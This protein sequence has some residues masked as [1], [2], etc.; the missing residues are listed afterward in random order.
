MPK[1]RPPPALP[2]NQLLARLPQGEY[3]RL[4]PHL[5]AVPLAFKQVLYRA[6]S[7]IDYAYFPNRG[8]TS[9]L[10]IMEDGSAI[11]VATVGNEGVVGM[12]AFLGAKTSPNEV[13]VQ[14]EGD[15]LRMPAEAL[16]E[17]ASRD[18]PLRRL[19]VLYQVAFHTQVSQSVACNGLHSV[20]K[21]CCRWL[22]MTHDR[23]Q[24]DVMPLTH[25]FLAVMLG[26][27]RSSVTEVLQP[28]QEQGLIR[29]SRGRITVVDRAGLE[30][31][32]CE[33]YRSVKDEFD[34]LFG[35][36]GENA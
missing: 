18:G 28:L 21:R 22:L 31:A 7:S 14:V 16:H 10:T 33:C 6:R 29:N 11:E 15:G 35:P 24:A 36:A 23:V 27:Q 2:E 32:S 20:Q 19:L 9:A 25:E 34:R 4:L 30:A 26:V 12:L 3:Q 5:E 13:I 1:T 8:V 17:E